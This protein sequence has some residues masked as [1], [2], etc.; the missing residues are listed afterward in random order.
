MPLAISTV[1]IVVLFNLLKVVFANVAMAET[2][3]AVDFCVIIFE[4]LTL[5]SF[6]LMNMVDQITT[7]ALWTL[8]LSGAVSV[9]YKIYYGFKY[10][11]WA[12][13]IKGIFSRK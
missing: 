13:K 12:S 9:I 5:V 7:I 11:S 2:I 8:V 6:A 3:E 10:D 1:V 4:L